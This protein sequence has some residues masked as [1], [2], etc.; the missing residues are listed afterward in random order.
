[1]FFLSRNNDVNKT[2]VLFGIVNMSRLTVS[3]NTSLSVRRVK[4]ALKHD[5]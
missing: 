3:K 1:M 2:L 5:T 4:A